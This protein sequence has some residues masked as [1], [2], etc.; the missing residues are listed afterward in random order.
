MTKTKKFL[1]VV[2]VLLLAVGGFWLYWE[3]ELSLGDYLPQQDRYE[4]SLIG[5]VLE[6]HDIYEVDASAAEQIV[7]CLNNA[8]A[9]RGPSFVSHN[10]ESF[11]VTVFYLEEPRPM[12]SVTLIDDGRI[13][14]YNSKDG[15]Q[16]FFE[17]GESLYQQ[18]KAIA[19]NLPVKE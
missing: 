5:V 19:E 2:L 8:A 11:S 7:N 18:I 10:R 4:V 6:G 1:L 12:V 15:R 17:G 9:D 16:Y 14:L 13:G 3:Q